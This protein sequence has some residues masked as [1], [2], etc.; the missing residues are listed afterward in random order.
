LSFIKQGST[1]EYKILHWLG[2]N[3]VTLYRCSYIYAPALPKLTPL[4]S[5]NLSNTYLFCF[6]LY[7]L[8]LLNG[9]SKFTLQNNLLSFVLKLGT[10]TWLE[11]RQWLKIESQN[12][13]Y[14]NNVQLLAF[15]LNLLK[16]VWFDIILQQLS[17][18]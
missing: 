3:K 8:I 14:N 6:S 12:L 9:H 2:Y 1:K 18:I 4:Y 17:H 5:S 15:E 11:N 16:F 10:N 7:V 13:S